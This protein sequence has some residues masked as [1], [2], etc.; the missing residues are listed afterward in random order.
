MSKVYNI[1][2]NINFFDEL[3]KSLDVDENFDDENTCLITNEPLTH[4]FVQ[5]QCNHK[6]NY[7]ALYNDIKNHKQKFNGLEGNSSHLQT[8]EIRCPY[9]R[10]KQTGLLP[11][12]EEFGLPGLHG[13][14]YID[15]NRKHNPVNTHNKYYNQC[16]YLTPN[17]NYDPSGNNVLDPNLVDV[18]FFKCYNSSHYITSSFIEGYT[19]EPMSV[20]FTHKKKLIK[21]NN[22]MIK[23]KQKEDNIKVKTEAKLKAKLEKEEAKLKAKAEKQTT[24]KPL[25]NIV[26]GPSTIVPSNNSVLCIEILKSGPNKGKQCGGKLYIDSYCKRHDKN[27]YLEN[28]LIYPEQNPKI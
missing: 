3:Y 12:Y 15:P 17:P 23:N 18:Q 6:F 26:I 10:N 13:V 9:C 27:K 4:K 19:G 24:K 1:E 11:Y 22:S 21:E 8:N 16:Q 14:N 7:N 2:G 28:T 20:C 5:L 25:E